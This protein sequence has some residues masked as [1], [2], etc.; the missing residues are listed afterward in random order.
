MLKMRVPDV[1][2]MIYDYEFDSSDR[3]EKYDLIRCILDKKLAD[4]GN[5]KTVIENHDTIKKEVAASLNVTEDFVEE[6]LTDIYNYPEIMMTYK[7]DVS[8]FEYEVLD[9]DTDHDSEDED[10]EDE[11]D[12]EEEDE[13]EDDE[14]DEDD[15][16]YSQ[17]AEERIIEVDYDSSISRIEKKVKLNLV[18]SCLTLGISI[19]NVVGF[20]IKK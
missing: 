14:D 5:F 11:D 6:M 1:F 7:D 16:K 15:E 3:E 10:E 17:E 19:L 13:D 12:E 20:F 8:K 2:P 18:V 9:D 4:K